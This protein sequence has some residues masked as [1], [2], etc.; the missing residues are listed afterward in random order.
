MLCGISVEL[1]RSA[2]GRGRARSAEAHK[3]L[4]KKPGLLSRRISDC[5]IVRVFVVWV[6]HFDAACVGDAEHSAGMINIADNHSHTPARRVKTKQR[7]TNLSLEASAKT[8]E[9]VCRPVVC[10][11]QRRVCADPRTRRAPAAFAARQAFENVELSGHDAHH[12]LSKNG[13]R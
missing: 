1:D 2:S 12:P 3:P 10:A 4:F 11:Q 8:V 13:W 5:N 6:F 7:R 9:L